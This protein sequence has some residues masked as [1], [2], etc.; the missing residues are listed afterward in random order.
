MG[1]LSPTPI[2]CYTE[3]RGLCRKGSRTK[4]RSEWNGTERASWRFLG[5]CFLK[6]EVNPGRR[7]MHKREGSHVRKAFAHILPHLGKRVCSRTSWKESGEPAEG[8]V[9]RGQE[10][11]RLDFQEAAVHGNKISSLKDVFK[12]NCLGCCRSRRLGT[13]R[14]RK[15][16][17]QP[18]SL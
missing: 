18:G 3:S 15:Q 8:L 2:V 10:A 5:A 4:D 9:A 13:Y 11:G 14:H 1:C 12:V 7:M 6:Q 16:T 17:N